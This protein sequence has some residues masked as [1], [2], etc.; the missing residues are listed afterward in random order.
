MRA[1]TYV[2]NGGYAKSR[3]NAKILI[4]NGN[5]MLDGKKIVK[6]SQD[7]DETIP[8]SVDIINKPRFVSRGGE[9]I[10]F[11]IEHFNIEQ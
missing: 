8:H 4:E 7:V 2:F 10:D 11:A 5:V 1:D 6:P 9:K 3:Q